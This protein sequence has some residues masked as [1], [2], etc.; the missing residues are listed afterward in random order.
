M[1]LKTYV[2]VIFSMLIAISSIAQQ[3]A[4]EGVAYG[5]MS[6]VR[7]P[8]DVSNQYFVMFKT[9]PG[10]NER[11]M[12]LS[13]GA[14][15]LYEYSIIP[16]Y[17]IQVPNQA[18]LKLINMDRRVEFTDPVQVYYAL[19]SEDDPEM[20]DV[21]GDQ[22]SPGDA[23]QD[24]VGAWIEQLDNSR[25][26][27]TIKVSDLSAVNPT[28]GDGLPVNGVWK[29]AFTLQN[30]GTVPD[31]YFVQ[32]RKPESGAPDFG[33]GFVDE[34]GINSEQGA[35]DQGTILPGEGK[36]VMVITNAV[37]SGA[38][39][40][41]G[42]P[43][44]GD[45]LTA[46][47]AEAS[48]LVGA[49]GTGFITTLD[50]APD[51]GPGRDYPVQ[52]ILPPYNISPEELEFENISL[53]ESATLQLTV[54]N[55]TSG[56][57]NFT[58]VESNHPEFAV[59]PNSVVVPPSTQQ[60][61]TVT[62][63]PTSEGRKLGLIIF[64]AEGSSN[65][66]AVTVRGNVPAQ[67]QAE[68]IPWGVDTVRA[69]AV[70]G[71]TKGQPIKLAVLDTGIDSL[72]YELDARYKGGYNFVLK[73]PHPWDGHSHGTHV[74]G[75][76]AA[77][78]N[79][80]GVVGVAPDIDLYSLKV[81]S[82]AGSG[83]SADILAAIDWCVQNGMNIA[84]M[85]LGGG[86]GITL[87]TGQAVRA[88]VYSPT[89]DAAYQAAYDAG[90]LIICA[91]GN[92]G[93]PVVMY[94]AA[95]PSNMAIGAIGKNLALASFSNYGAEQ[96]VVAPGV[97]VKST[98]PM[99]TGRDSRVDLAGTSLE[100]NELQFCALTSS[101]GISARTVYCGK[102]L[103]PSDFPASVA[104]KIALIQRGDST[105]ASKVSKAQDAGA[106]AAI[107][108]NN[109]EGNFNGTMGTARD[110]ANN[111]D[112]IP[113]VSLSM[114]DGQALVSLGSPIITLVNRVDDFNKY[115]GT[116]MATPHASAVAALAWSI[117]PA[118]TNDQVRNILRTTSRDLGVPGF[119]PQFGDGLID[120]AG[121]VQAAR[122]SLPDS[123]TTPTLTPANTTLTWTGGPYTAVTADPAAC[124]P[125][126]C[127]EYTFVVNVPQSYYAI[128]TSHTVRVHISW[129]NSNTDFDMYVYDEEGNL[130]NSSPQGNTTFEEVNLNQLTT[131]RYT[132]Q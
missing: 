121:A 31:E 97:D 46:P 43:Q 15:I 68:V 119:D 85:S 27:F 26:Q 37:L 122:E 29:I 84:S 41:N 73:N 116:S 9:A 101:S 86:I 13:L 90:L 6:L 80:V 70:W 40:Q 87:P 56:E 17:A 30:G 132:V 1:R 88:P 22:V 111:R 14:T 18:T 112:W 82:D 51:D 76:I 124:T 50:R 102:G 19:G 99:G 64:T 78:L 25:L 106:I 61:F 107:I 115:S 118:L 42:Y 100:A 54:T 12:I 120:A 4:K 125:L 16:A 92:D 21:T 74:S 117:N 3:Q 47:Y 5:G 35:V 104:G 93:E 58:T 71:A 83:T 28:T 24:I 75:T 2:C 94:P 128:N 95:Y 126:T 91:S 48:Q 34:N 113:G 110:D 49:A 96:E 72:H 32:M 39:N 123:D 44:N 11:N 57:L 81:L 62:F 20:T 129:D 60:V 55:T 8:Q 103:S 33:W 10:I 63:T 66:V 67:Q 45:V 105:F 7:Q 127:D 65:P 109:V 52:T 89:E 53:G 98:V 130:V 69:P 108:Y 36:I 77:E 38:P 23:T 59:T 79:G 114:S 131:G